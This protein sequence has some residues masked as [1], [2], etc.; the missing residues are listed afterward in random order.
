MKKYV[1]IYLYLIVCTSLNA[2]QLAAREEQLIDSM[3]NANYKPDEPG[4][5]LLIAK[6]GQPIFKK[7]YGLANLEFNVPNRT[8]FIFP[9]ASMSKQ[10]TA[11]CI[12]KLAQEGKVDLQD[13]ITMYLP[14][15]NTH[16]KSITIEN[17]LNHTSG[18]NDFAAKTDYPGLAI[19]ELSHEDLINTFMN[20]SLVFEPGTHF[21]YSNSGYALAGMIVEKVSGMSLNQF[22]QQHIFDPLEMDHTSFGTYDSLVKNA[23]Y[24]YN[25]GSNGKYKPIEYRSWSSLFGAGEILTNLDDLLKWDNSLYTE[26]VLTKKSLEKA[27][28]AFILPNGQSTNYGLGWTSSNFRGLQIIEHAG[29]MNGFASDGIRIPSK[30]LF[31]AILSNKPS[32]WQ[33]P[34]LS[35]LIKVLLHFDQPLVKNSQ[36]DTKTL[37]DYSGVYAVNSNLFATQAHEPVYQYFTV[38]GDTLYT[39]SAGYKKGPIFNVGKDLFVPAWWDDQYY[40]FNRNDK[41]DIIS[42][43]LFNDPLPYGPHE[44]QIKTDLPLPK[45]KQV[46]KITADKLALL[47]GR[48]D[49]TGGLVLPVIVEGSKFYFSLPGQ[50]KEEYFAENETHFFSKNTDVTLEFTL[51]GL[52]VSEMKIKSQGM[53]YVGRKIE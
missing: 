30:H 10:F 44:V 39:Q 2:Q 38:S 45:E 20:D 33:A 18:I 46:M 12:L 8:E 16:G 31:I 40:Q 52:A 27:W 13:N 28:K 35:Y 25:I 47:K 15:Y 48:Y 36:I 21:G 26:Q 6:D 7:G 14:D 32:S 53:E 50:E 3:M 1:F 5:V 17:I 4:A 9:I 42:V 34:L 37:I 29:G 41:G 23:V 24:G 49:F 51:D 11:V 43:E 19:Q 22:R